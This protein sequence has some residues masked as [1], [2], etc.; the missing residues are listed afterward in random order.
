DFDIWVID[1]R[2]LYANR[3][4]FPMAHRLLVGDIGATLKQVQDDL[5]PSVYALIVTRGHN[6]DEEALYH[7]APLTLPSPP[8]GEGKT[9]APSPL[10]GEGRVRGLGYVGMIGSK[11]K[12][13][14]I[15]E[16]LIA[17]GIPEEALTRV[18]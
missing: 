16:D 14:L 5:S 3:Q 13:R 17:R 6:H 15:Y 9:I 7:L 11:R 12:I 10:G 8:R 1:D 4:R 18:H 2:E